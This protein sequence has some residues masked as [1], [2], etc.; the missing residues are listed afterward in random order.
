M[1]SIV[2]IIFALCNCLSSIKASEI[3]IEH[4]FRLCDSDESIL[5]KFGIDEKSNT[6]IQGKKF[7][8]YYVDTLD[9]L[10]NKSNWSIRFREKN[11]KVE[12]TIKNKIDPIVDVSKYS[13]IECE[14][15]LHGTTKEYACKL[16]SEVSINDF[17]KILKGSK[18][19]TTL[20][21]KVQLE[22][23]KDL[24][25]VHESAKVW[26][27]LDAE[28]HQW[29]DKK[30]GAISVDLIHSEKD[31]SAT[32]NEISIRYPVS[33]SNTFSKKFEEY[34]QN[35]GVGLCSDQMQWGIDKFD[36]IEI[37]N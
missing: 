17:E 21:S 23:I 36:V 29:N 18:N 2:I 31:N 33:N 8:I 22:L 15:N 25:V 11:N 28:R 1:K 35:S 19:W 5:E 27:V 37:L 7:K 14:Y 20:L 16:T 4:Q 9:R 13:N 26:G 24:N 10:Y 6:E 3:K 34:L 32:Y 30:L 12:L